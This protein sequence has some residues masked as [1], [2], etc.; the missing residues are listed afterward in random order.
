[1]LHG[2]EESVMTVMTVMMVMTCYVLCEEVG[3]G[4]GVMESAAFAR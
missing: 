4:G 1:V 2:S 3:G